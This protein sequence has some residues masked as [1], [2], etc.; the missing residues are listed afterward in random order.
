MSDVK[1]KRRRSRKTLYTTKSSSRRRVENAAASAPFVISEAEIVKYVENEFV[2]TLPFWRCFVD[3]RA[4]SPSRSVSVLERHT[5]LHCRIP[6][7]SFRD[8]QVVWAVTTVTVQ[9]IGCRG[10]AGDADRQRHTWRIGTMHFVH[11]GSPALFAK[12][13]FHIQSVVHYD[14]PSVLQCVAGTMVN[15]GLVLYSCIRWVLAQREGIQLVLLE[16]DAPAG[17]SAATASYAMGGDGGEVPFRPHMDM[18][19]EGLLDA[20]TA[21][22]PA[23]Y[24]LLCP[25]PTAR[26]LVLGMGGNSMAVALR[27][28]LGPAV[29]IDVVEME[30][31]V[32]AACR[33]AGTFGA[34]DQ[35]FTVHLETAE[36]IMPTFADNTFDFIFMDLFDPMNASMNTE[37]S[38]AYQCMQKLT[39]GGLLLVNDH[40]LPSPKSLAKFTELCGNANV[41]VVNLHGSIESVVAC[42]RTNGDA[43]TEGLLFDCRKGMMDAVHTQLYAQ[44]APGLLPSP[45]WIASD[46]TLVVNG[47]P[48]RLFVS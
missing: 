31:A 45:S 7:V 4:N 37:G 1:T 6:C 42:M 23:H 33:H 44:L 19:A 35:P 13:S 24:R 15:F 28:I 27:C 39:L 47:K 21:R 30:P 34:P 8:V 5:A 25:P 40:Q 22:C 32:A 2:C 16:A 18:P 9:C 10:A 3:L 46:E 11:V 41:T 29:R 17:P 12:N 48:C 20:N 14:A 36:T 43:A 26:I 38:I